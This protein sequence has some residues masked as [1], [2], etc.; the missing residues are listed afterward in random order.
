MWSFQQ[1][2]KHIKAGLTGAKDTPR[3]RTFKQV[4]DALYLLADE[5]GVSAFKGDKL[6]ALRE[7]QVWADRPVCLGVFPALGRPAPVTTAP[8]SVFELAQ[9]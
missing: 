6:K 8:R 2:E 7:A 4:L 5:K 9:R 3:W 1:A